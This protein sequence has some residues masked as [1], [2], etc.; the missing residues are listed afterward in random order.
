MAAETPQ[1]S[2]PLM[3]LSRWLALIAFLVGVGGALYLWG[4][5]AQTLVLVPVPVR[6]LPAYH[7]IQP[8][9][10]AQRAYPSRHLTSATLRETAQIVGSYTLVNV[11]QQK[12]L[13]RDQLGAVVDTALISG[14]VAIGIP[15]TPAMVLG[16][17]L[18][19]SDLVDVIFVPTASDAQPSLKPVLFENLLVLDVKSVVTE[20]AADSSQPYVVV[21]ALPLDRRD[22]FVAHSTRDTL[23]LA[24]RIRQ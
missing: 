13:S 24:R 1:I 22:E 3:P 23:L 16:G 14:T 11:S 12:P 21:I 10:L 18:Q 7:Q 5:E 15:A 6:D 2:G 9:D 19:L 17:S 4:H 20:K 8:G